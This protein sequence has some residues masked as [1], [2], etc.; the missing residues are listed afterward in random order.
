MLP[1]FQTYSKEIGA[2]GAVV[3]AFALNQIF[4][5]RP[6]LRYGVLH[7]FNFIVDHTTADDDGNLVAKKEIIRTASI[8]LT[9]AGRSTANNVEITFNWQPPFLNAWPARHYDAKHSP[10]GRY[11]ISLESLAPSESFGIEILSIGQAELP[12]IAALRCDECN[13]KLV[14]MRSQPAQ[15]QWF[16]G[17]VI[18]I[19]VAG[20][21]AIGYSS[22]WLVEA[23]SA[24]SS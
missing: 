21:A 23:L 2:F 16:V 14:S 15:S 24:A 20:V 7:S 5:L 12:L 19:M 11:T 18:V 10:Q 9:N 3:F 1:F 6:K 8:T 17:L 13:G 22:V 4:R